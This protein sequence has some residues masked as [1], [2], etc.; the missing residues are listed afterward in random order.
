MPLLAKIK[1]FVSP[2]RSNPQALAQFPALDAL[3]GNQSVGQIS[4]QISGEAALQSSAVSCCLNIIATN[5]AG[6]PLEVMDADDNA[7]QSTQG[8]ALRRVISQPSSNATRWD[9]IASI[10]RN[11]A[12]YG[13]AFAFVRRAQS[14]RVEK[15]IALPPR[16]VETHCASDPT[17]DEPNRYLISS[18]NEGDIYAGDGRLIHFK[19]V[20]NDTLSGTS[21]LGVGN[22]VIQIALLQDI[23]VS[24]FSRAGM[25]PSIAMEL[26]EGKRMSDETYRRLEES[27]W[28]A[29]GGAKNAGSIPIGDAGAK[30]VTLN[31]SD[32]ETKMLAL[33]EFQVRE[34]AR[35]FRVPIHMLGLT[36]TGSNAKSTAEKAIEFINQTLRAYGNVIENGL[37][38]LVARDSGLRFRFDYRPLLKTTIRD[39]SSAYAMASA[40]GSISK[41]EYREVL[42]LAAMEGGDEPALAVQNQPA[43]QPDNESRNEM[44]DTN[45]SNEE[46]S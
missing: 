10:A 21:L 29:Y 34:I 44:T 9:F 43:A 11:L 20:G 13:N 28:Q 7:A 41:N 39:A 40:T 2:N 4:G 5:I 30:F 6:L 24:A 16:S 1:E 3:K 45:Q 22:K 25:R 18:S 19:L 37:N 26:P 31:A 14:G 17:L 42:N 36:E 23:A 12:L 27:L 38:S 35:L 46:R 32:Q 8:R 33:R 15:L